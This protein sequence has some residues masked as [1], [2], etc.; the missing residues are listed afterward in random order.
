[1]WVLEGQ[2]ID[3]GDEISHPFNLLKQRRFGIPRFGHFSMR[4]S[5]GLR[6]LWRIYFA[7]ILTLENPPNYYCCGGTDMALKARGLPHKATRISRSHL[8]FAVCSAAVAVVA[9]GC[10]V[11]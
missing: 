2:D 4:R 9:T 7:P 10:L 11:A 5:H 6:S 1:M 8:R 3:G